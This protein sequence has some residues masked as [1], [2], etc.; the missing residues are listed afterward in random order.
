MALLVL[1]PGRLRRAWALLFAGAGVA[2]ALPRLLELTSA[3]TAPHLPDGAARSAALGVAAGAAAAGLLWTLANAYAV[4]SKGAERWLRPAGAGALAVMLTVAVAVGVVSSDRI[5][6]GIN[7]Q[8]DAFVDLG[9]T[10]T[11]GASAVSRLTSGGGNRYDYWRV[12]WHAWQEHPVRGVG[13][14]NYDGPYFAQRAT[15]EDVRQPHSLPLQTLSELGLVGMGLLLVFLAGVGWGAAR[16]VRAA[17]MSPAAHV[18]AVA[19]IGTFIAWLV[20]TSVDWIHLLPGVTASALACAALL[21]RQIPRAVVVA[22]AARPVRRRVAAAVLVAGVLALTAVSLSRQGL[23]EYFRDA[24]RKD[25]A[26]RPDEAVVQV[27]RSLRLDPESVEAYQ[28]KAAALARFNQASAARRTLLDAT[29]RESKDFV[30]WALL[31]D[32][33]V[34]MGDFGE[35]HDAYSRAH[36]L[37]PRDQTLAALSRD[38]RSATT[39]SGG[40]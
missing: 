15:T 28:L 39:G 31:G 10:R 17:R 20:H 9:A 16:A 5:A 4:R 11:S 34:R 38:P 13:A 6:D 37:N 23:A 33:A 40:P 8:Y 29:H 27:D 22:P 32:L 24:A 18:I 1:V 12:A 25:L 14:G 35:A 2:V 36:N 19:S 7:R 21:V 26:A 3:G 30:T